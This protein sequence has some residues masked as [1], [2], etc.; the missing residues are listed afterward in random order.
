MRIE[1][2]L[3]QSAERCPDKSALAAGGRRLSYAGLHDLSGRLAASL[4]AAGVA[5][6]DRVLV[7]M[8][9]TWQA[10][11]SIFAIWKVGA[12]FCPVN[13]SSKA[14]RLSFIIGNCRPAAIIVQGKLANAVVEAQGNAP[15]SARLIVTTPHPPLGDAL[16]FEA[17]L[18]V[19]PLPGPGGLSE[20]DLAMII[21]TSGSTGEPKG[22]MMAHRNMDAAAGSITSYLENTADD[23]ILNVLPM[24]FG[25]GLYQLITS[26]RVGATLVLEKSFAFPYAIFER[27][28]DERVTG[29][30]L[31]PPMAAM[32]LRMHDLDPALFASLRYVTSAA[33]PLPVT[34][35]AQIRALLPHVH[36][37]SMYGQTECTRAARLPPEELDRRPGSVGIAIPGTRVA[38]VDE[39]GHPV[40]AGETGELAVSGPHVMRGYWQDPAAT[41]RALRPDPKSGETRLH[42]GDLFTMDAGGFLTF[43]ARKDDIIKSRGEKVAPKE[44]E[45]VLHSLAGVAE[46]VVTGVPDPV[47]GEA[48]KAIVVA[49]DPALSDRDVIRHCARNLEDH[50]VPKFVEFRAELPKTDTGKV[51]RRLAAATSKQTG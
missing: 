2:T 37:H 6:G 46:A 29:F 10:A 42:T 23:V 7:V 26:V 24:S 40:P 25:Y 45:A 17:C 12:V 48:V 14:A 38:V 15:D 9:N 20:D 51:S 49:S 32:L 41:A 4:V 39:V 50:M 36:L 1:D 34:H 19:P 8:E 11:V 33:A 47:M 30:P 18:D 28:R 43:I 3:H 16:G 35:I 21:Y 31:V 5:R 27:I 13:P 22:V 44:V